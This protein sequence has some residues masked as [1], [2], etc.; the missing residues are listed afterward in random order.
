MPKV[1][2]YH[3]EPAVP[4]DVD[5]D[6]QKPME[7]VMRGA[8]PYRERP[9]PRT[10][11][12]VGP[13][14]RLMVFRISLSVATLI[15]V[16]AVAPHW[17]MIPIWALFSTYIVDY[18]LG[19]RSAQRWQMIAY[20]YGNPP[21]EPRST[22]ARRVGVGRAI[23]IV[24]QEMV[25]A[26]A[27]VALQTYDEPGPTGRLTRS[28]PEALDA[29][30]KLMAQVEQLQDEMRNLRV[31]VNTQRQT[32]TEVV[33]RQME[34]GAERAPSGTPRKVGQLHENVV[35]ALRGR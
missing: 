6:F 20:Q 27:N 35:R 28:E 3:G 21:E 19:W 9:L 11:A 24:Q 15:L 14:R 5:A 13:S 16:T 17:Y 33:D 8:T 34:S 31:R 2:T 26:A 12:P 30:P 10:V 22:L 29:V 18:V 1:V 7:A 23:Q 4:L 32:L 25:E